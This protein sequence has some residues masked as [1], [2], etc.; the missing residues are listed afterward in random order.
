MA[1]S[2]LIHS[3]ACDEG[4]QLY[5][6]MQSVDI[7]NDEHS[8]ELL[9]HIIELW[10]TIRGF[11]IAG[12]WLEDYKKVMNTSKVLDCVRTKEEGL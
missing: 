8:A 4:V 9:H 1:K 5:W 2:S 12:S 6:A 10:V 7:D 3:V 11:S